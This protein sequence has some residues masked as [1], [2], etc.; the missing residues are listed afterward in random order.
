MIKVDTYKADPAW[1]RA[2]AQAGAQLALSDR[3][4]LS[5]KLRISLVDH[6]NFHCFFCHN[7]GQGPLGRAG[8]A[9]SAAQVA[10]LC[11][12]ALEAGVRE[13]KLTGGE[14]LLYRHGDERIA[15]VVARIAALRSHY[16]FGL[17]M[18]TNALLLSGQAEALS[19][20]GLDRVTVSL[21]TLDAETLRATVHKRGSQRTIERV[22]AGIEAAR[23]AGLGPLKVNMVL[24]GEGESAP[25]N[26]GEVGAMAD[27]CRATGVDE[28]RLYTLL[29]NRSF[30]GRDFQAR[31]RFWTPE[32]AREVAGQL[33]EEAGRA[34]AFAIAAAGFAERW[35]RTA[36]PKPTL[37]FHL[38]RLS[39]A[40]EAMEDGRFDHDGLS[41]EGPYAIRLSAAGVLRGCLEGGRAK[42]LLGLLRSGANHEL[43]RA[44]EEARATLLPDEVDVASEGWPALR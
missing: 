3:D 35:K 4:Q 33:F 13:I 36:Y 11:E 22:A 31:Y 21:H 5:R 15:D 34:D 2:A 10:R 37:R 17:S 12:A 14:P 16:V 25:G 30:H 20:A 42:P 44:F 32:V 43:V 39:V 1:G 8:V 6:C 40:I 7:E 18:T 28:L 9:M 27:L 23:S 26:L 41:A 24:F 19:A 38:D 29:S